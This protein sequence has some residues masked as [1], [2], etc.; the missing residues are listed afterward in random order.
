VIGRWGF[1]CHITVGPGLIRAVGPP[2]ATI[3]KFPC[4]S[5]RP[6]NPGGFGEMREKRRA[7]LPRKKIGDHPPAPKIPF[8]RPFAC[9]QN[10][11]GPLPNGSFVQQPG[12][13]QRLRR[14]AP[15]DPRCRIPTCRFSKNGI[16]RKRPPS[17][18]RRNLRNRGND[19]SSRLVDPRAST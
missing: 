4:P 17:F 19:E 14:G 7:R 8:T 3:V 18:P 1:V 13:I 16:Q 2:V 10:R 6:G 9:F 15:P 11:R 5:V 12:V